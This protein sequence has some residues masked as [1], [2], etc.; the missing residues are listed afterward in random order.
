[1]RGRQDDWLAYEA[2][3]SPAEVAHHVEAVPFLDVVMFGM[4]AIV[5]H[6][7]RLVAVGWVSPMSHDIEFATASTAP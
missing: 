6:G 3:E 2:T 7:G 5:T 1:M 4:L